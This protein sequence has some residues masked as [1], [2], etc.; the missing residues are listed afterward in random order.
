[1]AQ[2]ESRGVQI[3]FRGSFAVEEVK[4]EV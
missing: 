3:K 1:M 2:G 4:S